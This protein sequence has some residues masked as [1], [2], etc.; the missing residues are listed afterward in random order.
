MKTTKNIPPQV[1]AK[2]GLIRKLNKFLPITLLLTTAWLT[3]L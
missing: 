1:W 2:I 3:K